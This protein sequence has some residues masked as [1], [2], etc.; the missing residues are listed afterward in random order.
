MIGVTSPFSGPRSEGGGDALNGARLAI[1]RLNQQNLQ[2]GDKPV[3]FE[4][5][6][7]DD[8]GMPA[9]GMQ[10]AREFAQAGVS[11]VIGP[12]TSAVALAVAR[13]YNQNRVPMLT[14]ATHPAVTR[15]DYEYVFRLLAS[16]AELGRKMV[17][18]AASSLKVRRVAVIQDGS[19]YA[20]GLVSE[21]QAASQKEGVQLAVQLQL[22]EAA[23][24]PEL[25]GVLQQVRNAKSDAVFFA[26]YPPLSARILQEMHQM[27]LALPLMAGDAQC[28]I[29]MLRLI[30]DFLDNGVYCVQS[31]V[32]LTR[33]ADGAVFAAAF[34]TR[35]SQPPDVYAGNFYDGV[36]LLAQAM[37]T[38]GSTRPEQ[39]LPALARSRYKG[40]TATYEFNARHDLKDSAATILRLKDGALVP[41]ASF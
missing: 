36:M 40:V 23:H 6:V 20:E 4:L 3:R 2:I 15:P 13:I 39:F 28:S 12:M 10:V 9:R 17:Q 18:Y 24:D 34:Q 25:R 29:E 11:G 14:V 22:S 1:D 27:R 26:G 19:G 7:K 35:Y 31:G 8:H 5:L 16:D 32:W 37:K 38:A 21:L 30:G 33:V 41:M